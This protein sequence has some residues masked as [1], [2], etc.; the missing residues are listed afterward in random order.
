MDK[1]TFVPGAYS[2]TITATLDDNSSATE[3]VSLSIVLLDPLT[4]MSF[5]VVSQPITRFTDSGITTH[6]VLVVTKVPTNP[7]PVPN[8]TYTIV[9]Q[10]A[11][12]A[13]N[14]M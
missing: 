10:S 2:G 12:S 3:V 9:P 1:L 7:Y 8:L 5:S 6:P 4:A 11:A 14:T 13:L